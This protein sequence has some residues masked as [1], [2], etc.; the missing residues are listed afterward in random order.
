MLVL[1]TTFLIEIQQQSIYISKIEKGAFWYNPNL[2]KVIIP[3]ACH[4]IPESAF[5]RCCLE[6]VIFHNN[7][8]KIGAEAFVHNP[9]LKKVIL[10]TGCEVDPEAFDE[11][12]EIIYSDDLE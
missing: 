9:N 6:E 11:G 7:V 3:E 4:E 10:P 2:K 8:K 12:V 1:F 5:G